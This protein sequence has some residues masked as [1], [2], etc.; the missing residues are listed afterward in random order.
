M[1]QNPIVTKLRKRAQHKVTIDD[2]DLGK[3]DWIIRPLSTKELI[4]KQDDIDSL[5]KNESL[6][7][8]TQAELDDPNNQTSVVK[9]IRETIIPMMEMLVPRCALNPRIVVDLND[10]ALFDENSNTI[11]INDVPMAILSQLFN[12]ILQIS[13]IGKAAEEARKKL[14]TPT[15]DKQLPSSVKSAQ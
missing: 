11:H 14:P 9:S 2:K 4:E 5:P 6:A 3:S 7:G 15:T 10:P 8:L 12:E 13:G 1:A